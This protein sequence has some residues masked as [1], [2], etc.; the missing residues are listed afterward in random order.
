M[1]EIGGYI[2]LDRYSLP[3]L[4]EGAVALNC[5]R[6]ALAYIIR[7]KEIK[8]IRIP[9]FLCDSVKEVC[10]KENVVISYY[11][12]N[13]EFLPEEMELS[14]GE[15]LYLVNYYGQLDNKKI[16]YYRTKYKRVIVD[17][18]QAYFQMPVEGIDTIYTCRK[19][20]GVSDGAFLYT[21]KY[22]KRE[23]DVDES[24]SRMEFLHG[25]FERSASEF[26]EKYVRNN[27]LF[28]NED[29]KRMSR[30]T[31]NLLH[32]LDYKSIKGKRT[33]NFEVLHE[34]FR[35]IN[36]LKL[37]IPDGAFMYPLYYKKGALI[38][39]EL[40]IRKIY[41]PVLWPEVFSVCEESEPEYSMARDI[42][43]LPVDQ[44]YD[45]N[46]MQYI[47][48]TIKEIRKDI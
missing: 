15:W 33:K 44:R 19:F 10:K 26:Y 1:R 22:I 41:I 23:L 29:V 38:R 5:G 20:F 9:K 32:A 12:V 7:A 42:V 6:N 48:Q 16:E 24:Y 21:D 13:L 37:E 25:R 2:E 8:R 46:D 14:E 43:P 36:G 34:E 18:V 3:M 31:E 39:K 17:N 45:E 28:A 35:N 4:H 11:S 27:E 40:Q 30:L 47:I